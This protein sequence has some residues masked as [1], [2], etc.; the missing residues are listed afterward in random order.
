[1]ILYAYTSI[2]KKQSSNDKSSH[3]HSIGSQIRR[4]QEKELY[5]IVKMTVKSW[6]EHLEKSDLILVFLPGDNK[7]FF[8]SEGLLSKK[9]PRIQN[10]PFPCDQPKLSTAQLAFEKMMTVL[11][12]PKQEE[13]TKTPEDI[14]NESD[15]TVIEL[16]TPVGTNP[17]LLWLDSPVPNTPIDQEDFMRFIIEKQLEKQEEERQ[18]RTKKEIKTV[19]DIPKKKVVK[20]KPLYKKR[21]FWFL[22]TVSII[23]LIAFWFMADP[24]NTDYEYLE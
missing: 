6:A 15:E 12:K 17:E 8:Y 5:K 19:I 20:E 23:V 24:E 22:V 3:A 18:K 7:N 9:D 10:I 4:E 11:I 21:E 14:V 16:L 1:M 13:K 2:G